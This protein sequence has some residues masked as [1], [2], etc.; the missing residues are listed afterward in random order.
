MQKIDHKH[1]R[2]T[3]LSDNNCKALSNLKALVDDKLNVT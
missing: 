1:V 3:L 2:I